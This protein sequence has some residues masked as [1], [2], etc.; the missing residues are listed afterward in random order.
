MKLIKKINNN[1]A[2]GIDSS[3]KTLIVQGRGI[4]FG[5]FPMELFDLS[6]VERTYYNM[7][8]KYMDLIERL[9]EEVMKISSKIVQYAE[10]VLS[11]KLNPNLI[12]SL[13][14][15]I[16]FTLERTRKGI[17]FNYG[18]NYE[19]KYRH[20]EE[21]K[22]AEEM[23]EL[24]QKQFKA[25]FSKDEISIIAMHILEA[26]TFVETQSVVDLTDE[27]INE[28]TELVEK[29]LNIK[30]N[31]LDFNYYR[32]ATHIQYLLE[33]KNKNFI[34]SSDNKKLYDS[35]KKQYKEIYKCICKIREYFFK[36]LNMDISK[37]EQ[38]YLMIHINRVSSQEDCYR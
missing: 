10:D 8:D 19:M 32:F 22:I 24:M 12:F 1:Y 34:I 18:I 7:D 28:L 37:E 33:R 23:I 14:D 9:P 27:I 2:V 21:Y 20:P 11:V 6:K 15:H 25:K 30:F 17:S 26:K 31:R 38:L 16:N 29:E 13:A 35:M 3:G 5:K 4:G 36:K